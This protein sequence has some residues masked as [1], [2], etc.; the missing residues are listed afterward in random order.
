MTAYRTWSSMSPVRVEPVRRRT[1][2]NSV[3]VR[4]TMSAA[5]VNVVPMDIT[6][7]RKDLTLGHVYHVDVITEPIPVTRTPEPA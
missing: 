4:P 1:T 5:R 2:S 6:D 3:V 7:Q